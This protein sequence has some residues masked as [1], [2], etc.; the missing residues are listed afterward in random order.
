MGSR[1]RGDRFRWAD[2]EQNMLEDRARLAMANVGHE[3]KYCGSWWC[4]AFQKLSETRTS[5]IFILSFLFAITVCRPSDI[6]TNF[7]Y[8]LGHKLQGFCLACN[9][10]IIQPITWSSLISFLSVLTAESYL[11]GDHIVQNGEALKHFE[12]RL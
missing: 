12:T 2:G 1:A 7:H 11:P 3:L 10:I 6:V 9:I 8:L 5:N 4:G